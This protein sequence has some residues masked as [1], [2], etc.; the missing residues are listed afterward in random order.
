MISDRRFTWLLFILAAAAGV[1]SAVPAWTADGDDP[2]IPFPRP[3][4]HR[5]K[6]LEYH[7]KAVGAGGF[8][9]GRPGPECTVCHDRTDCIA[10]HATVMPRDHTNFWRTRGHGLMA[11]GVRERCAVCHREDYC[12]R[13]HN[14]TA[15]RS[16]IGN[17]RNRHCTVC[18]F[19]PGTSLA[20]NCT[21][22]HKGRSHVSA[23]HPVNPGLVCSQCHR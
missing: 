20:G 8:T 13:C 21:V 23:P 14:E 19:G 7:G 10:C 15:P 1:L 9:A 16:H 11:A 6:W 18:H 22:C 2:R 17:W 4:S 5:L 3:A 12:I